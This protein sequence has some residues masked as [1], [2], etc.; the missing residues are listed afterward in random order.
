MPLR[1]SAVKDLGGDFLRYLREIGRAG[2][3]VQTEGGL[4][5][6]LTSAI[7]VFCGA[8]AAVEGAAHRL[9]TTGGAGK[10]AAGQREV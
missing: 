10:R 8:A 3:I 2:L 7:P 4:S 5:R 1:A 9:G 6:F